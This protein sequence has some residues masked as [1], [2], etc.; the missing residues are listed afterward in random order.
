MSDKH[1]L[2]AGRKVPIATN[3]NVVLFNGDNSPSFY[4]PGKTLGPEKQMQMAMLRPTMQNY[5]F[6]RGIQKWHTLTYE[7]L[8]GITRQDLD[9]LGESITQI[10]IHHDVTMNATDT[11]NVLCTRGLSTHFTINYDGT[12]YQFLDCYHN[13]WATGD[14]NNMSVAIDMNNPVYPEEQ[15]RDPAG[16]RREIYQGKINGSVKTM[17]GYTEEQYETLIA[18]MKAFITP[19][20]IPNEDPWVPLPTL[21]A[22][23]FPPISETGEVINRL[24]KDPEK[25]KGFFGHYHC[26]GNKWDPGPAFDWMRVLSGIKGKRNSF[27][28]LLESSD[29]KNLSEVGGKLLEELFLSY[30][31]NAEFSEGGWYPIGANQSWHS[32]IHLSA[33]RDKQTQVL[34]MMEGTIVAVRN[35]ETVDLG[36]PSFVLIRHE[37][38]EIGSDGK[39]E[40]IYWYSLYMHL[41]PM[42]DATKLHAIPWMTDLLGSDAVVPDN[43]IYNM[44]GGKLSYIKGLPRTVDGTVITKNPDE[45][46]EAFFRGDILLVNL[47][48]QAGTPIGYVG[49]FGTSK[50]DLERQVHIEVFSEDNIFQR[51]NAGWNIVEG[52]TSEFSLV[53]VKRILK[54][55]QE[56]NANQTGRVSAF[57]KSSEIQSFFMAGSTDPLAARRDAFRRMICFHRSEWSPLM[58]WTRTAIQ[59]VGWQWESETAFGEWLLLWLPFQWLTKEVTS[60]LDLPAKHFF[61][62]FHP[63][64]L[65][66]QLNMT[67]AGDIA[68]T[69]EEASDSELENN[70]SEM[71]A[72]VAELTALKHKF[73]N[74]EATPQEIER[75]KELYQ[76]MDDHLDDKR[77]DIGADTRYDYH[78]SKAFDDW[79]PGEWRP[80]TGK[81]FESF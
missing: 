53:R 45:I 76:F 28:M 66:Q 65:L 10:A 55:I 59:T 78:Q 3:A 18:L 70:A 26:S 9:D 51:E 52:D 42:H 30:Y 80:P 17:L 68:Q 64:Y 39:P 58:N 41:E 62:T 75:I 60:A 49:R 21:A 77:A 81:S 4:H 54:P 37:R 38:E 24:L 31:R 57:L 71:A 27:P 2:F 6:R 5:S 35:V 33:P 22:N 25:F 23:C 50:G 29:Y 67:Y 11:F 34:S 20:N 19:V 46:L 32:G 12:L 1:I 15:Y 73:Q 13:A 69:A 48:C 7:Q 79:A 44:K 56:H 43:V 61:F 14:N 16:N 40:K 63:I 74:K 8:F 72:R 47:P 36:D